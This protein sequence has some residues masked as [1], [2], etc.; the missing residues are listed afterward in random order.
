MTAN[1]N[2]TTSTKNASVIDLGQLLAAER[3]YMIQRRQQAGRSA[4]IEADSLATALSGGGI[5]SATVC[6][7]IVEQLNEKELLGKT[8]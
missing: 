6:L 3:E 7:G 8:R 2:A 4:N 5:R 1:T